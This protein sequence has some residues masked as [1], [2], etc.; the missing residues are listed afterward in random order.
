MNFIMCLQNNDSISIFN[1]EKKILKV[2]EKKK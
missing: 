1:I 2:D